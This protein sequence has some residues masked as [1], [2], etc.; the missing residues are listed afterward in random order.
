M[1]WESLPVYSDN[2]VNVKNANIGEDQTLSKI[3]EVKFHWIK[4]QV[5]DST[6]TITYIPTTKMIANGFNKIYSKVKQA[7]FVEELSLTSED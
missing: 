7:K 1:K 5:R 6:I 2:Q 3:V 4:D